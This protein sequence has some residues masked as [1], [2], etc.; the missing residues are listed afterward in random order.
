MI[1]REKEIYKVNGVLQNLPGFDEQY[2]NIVD[3]IL[4]ITEKIWEQR[5]IWHIYDTYETDVLIHSGATKINGV[6]AVVSGTIKTLYAFP[7]RKM[8]GEAVIWSKHEAD[9]FYSSH[10]I[11]ST[12]TN[13][14]PTPYGAATNKPVFFRTIADCAIKANKIYEEWLVRD[15]LHLIQQL[16]FDAVE[17]AKRDDRYAKASYKNKIADVIKNEKRIKEKEFDDVL[18][19]LEMVKVLY[20][21]G[22]KLQNSEQLARYY[23]PLAKVHAICG[24][25][26]TGIQEIKTYFNNF[27]RSFKEVKFIIERITC[28]EI[29][30]KAEVAVRWTLTGKTTGQGFLKDIGVAGADKEIV[31]PGI[32]HYLVNEGG[33]MEEW[34]LFDAYDVLCQIYAEVNV[35]PALNSIPLP[36]VHQKNKQTTLAFIEEMNKVGKDVAKY[37]NVLQQYFAEEIIINISKPFEEIKGIE[38][39]ET[40]FWQPLLQAF[41]DAANKPYILLGGAYEGR[42]YVSFTGNIIGTWQNNWLGI[43]ATQQ[44]A[45]L[46]YSTTFLFENNIIIKAWYFLDVLDIIRQAGFQ[47]F[48]VKGWQHIPPPPATGDGIVNYLTQKTETQK[49]L[50]LTNAM[51]NG[52]L[53]YDGKTLQSMAQERFW[54]EKD[55][56]WYGPGGIGTTRGLKGFQDNHQLPFL[57]A[58]PDRGI[59]A[60]EGMDHFAQLAEGNYSCDFGFPSMYGTHMGDDWLGLPATGKKITLRVVD[61]WRRADNK[62]VENW[63]MIDMIDAL[64]QLGVDVFALLKAAIKNKK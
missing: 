36:T 19:A 13:L 26:L 58:F 10:R 49:T 2:H 24:K 59:T 44:P 15:N 33:V 8:G 50:D 41:P 64:E 34:L 53:E 62:L 40:Q 5:A 57:E 52:L 61:Y 28:N 32:G 45:C 35:K 25:E 43:P 9:A 3:Y 14:G 56:M 23:L 29:D 39:Y 6:E 37:K 38:N 4:K 63:V 21:D 17:M 60:K 48:P 20:E 16:G 7:D 31:M 1:F 55:M 18:D 12:A 54:A 42:Q 51:L 47:L 27:F 30:N 11:A 22:W 46:R